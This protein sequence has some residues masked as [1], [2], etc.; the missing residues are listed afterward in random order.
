MLS[1]EFSQLQTQRNVI[2]PP[3]VVLYQ[4]WLCVSRSQCCRKEDTFQG[5]RVG[6]CLTLGKEL[7][8]ET[9]MLTKQE[10]LL[11][12]VPGQRAA[13]LRNPGGWLCHVAHSLWF[14][15]DGV[16][17]RVVSGQSFWFRVLPSGELLSQ[18]GF[19]QGGFWEVGRTYG[20]VSSLLWTFPEFFWLV[21]AC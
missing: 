19:Q 20:L 6:S 11:G 10:T 8:K 17:F 14:Y 2:F 21:V 3:R 1:M 7:S 13:G 16:S 18:D 4:A 15:G 12:R 9:H 5:P